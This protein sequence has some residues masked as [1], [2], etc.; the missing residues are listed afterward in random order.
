MKLK[1][2]ED[3]QLLIKILKE[4]EKEEAQEYKCAGIQVRLRY[5]TLTEHSAIYYSQ[6]LLFPLDI[7][8]AHCSYVKAFI[9][10]YE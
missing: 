9:I 4:G 10:K 8:S 3:L 7:I 5:Y 2:E 1:T 6:E